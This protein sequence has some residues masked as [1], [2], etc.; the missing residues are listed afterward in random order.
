MTLTTVPRGRR[1]DE[2]GSA[3][4]ELAVITPLVL[5]VLTLLVA[6]G[7]IVTAHASLD[8]ATTAAARAASLAR[9]PATATSAAHSTSATTLHQQGLACHD[10]SLQADTTALATGPGTGGQVTVTSRC[11]VALADLLAP[12]LPGGLPLASEAASPLDP[13]RSKARGF[14]NS[15]GSAAE[16]PRAVA[17]RRGA[18]ND[19]TTAEAIA[20]VPDN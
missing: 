17:N 11:T 12:G 2:W 16:N 10:T 3:T 13:Y 18:A 9:T 8:A 7:R 15:E 1:E 20:P 6:G 4:V 19:R 14:G 5:L